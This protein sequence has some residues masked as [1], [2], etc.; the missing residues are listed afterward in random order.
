M[1]CSAKRTTHRIYDAHEDAYLDEEQC[2]VNWDAFFLPSKER[3][4][5]RTN[6]QLTKCIPEV[7]SGLARALCQCQADT[8]VRKFL[9]PGRGG[10]T[11]QETLEKEEK[12][13]AAGGPKTPI[14][15]WLAARNL[16]RFENGLAKMGV[17][18]ISDLVYLTDEDMRAL[19]VDDEARVHFHVRVVA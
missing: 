3:A 19:Q 10:S 15:R 8:A 14:G 17:K 16:E 7:Q 1:P 5:V 9:R 6:A 4:L 11:L 2:P 18:R 13:L 12:E